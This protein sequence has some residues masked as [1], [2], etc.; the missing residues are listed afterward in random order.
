MAGSIALLQGNYEEAKKYYEKSIQGNITPFS[1]TQAYVGHLA[2][3][4][5]HANQ[6][7]FKLAEEQIKT[8]V[9]RLEE[10]FLSDLP[11]YAEIIGNL[12]WVLLM[13]DKV[14]EAYL[15]AEKAAENYVNHVDRVFKYTSEKDKINF[16]RAAD[17]DFYATVA[18]RKINEPRV[19]ER[20]YLRILQYKNNILDQLAS[21]NEIRSI[22]LDPTI[23]R[24]FQEL[25]AKRKKLSG[26]KISLAKKL[27]EPGNY[28]K[29]KKEIDDLEGRLSL[30]HSEK[31]ISPGLAE[32]SMDRLLGSIPKNS[33]LIEFVKVNTDKFNEKSKE[34]KY[35]AIVVNSQK[36]INVVVLGKAKEID[37]ALA[38][39]KRSVR[40]VD[41][42][43]TIKT[44]ANKLYKSIFK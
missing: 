41:D 40:E 20:L 24:I 37:R 32:L 10:T 26:L 38:S 29:L 4:V 23:K 2:L 14:E 27:I 39:L 25:T 13:Q 3:G 44:K 6:N 28:L 9:K 17:I 7:N 21:Q 31:S 34:D 36:E 15:L 11:L 43:P 19:R 42:E 22:S 5:I 1:K 30:A 8:A 12:A 18:M 16:L 33:T 35:I